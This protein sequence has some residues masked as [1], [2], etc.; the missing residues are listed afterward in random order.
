[1][2]YKFFAKKI[3]VGGLNGVGGPPP[4]EKQFSGKSLGV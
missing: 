2:Y 4:D 1:M 3:L